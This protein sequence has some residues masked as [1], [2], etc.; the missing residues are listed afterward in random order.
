[1]KEHFNWRRNEFQQ[2]GTDYG[3]IDEVAAYDARMRKMRDVDAEKSAWGRVHL[4]VRRRRS[5]RM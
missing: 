3:S 4:P 1:M 5:V 2:I